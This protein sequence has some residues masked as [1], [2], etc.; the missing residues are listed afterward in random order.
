MI[1]DALMTTM[2]R[3]VRMMRCMAKYP[4]KEAKKVVGSEATLRTM[5][6]ERKTKEPARRTVRRHEQ[7]WR[8]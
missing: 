4:I 7:A 8:R 3:N 2:T 5:A 6:K 1:R